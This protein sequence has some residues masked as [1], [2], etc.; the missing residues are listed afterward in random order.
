MRQ[1]NDGTLQTGGLIAIIL[2]IS[3]LVTHR[4]SVYHSFDEEKG[5]KPFN[6]EDRTDS[7]SEECFR[8]DAIP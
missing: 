3:L 4:P 2:R 8:A 1:R 5:N 7:T 6:A